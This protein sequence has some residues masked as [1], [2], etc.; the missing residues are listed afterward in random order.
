MVVCEPYLYAHTYACMHKWKNKKDLETFLTIIPL[1]VQRQDK[2]K[3]Y[4]SKILSWNT[5]TLKEF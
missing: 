4:K 5:G 3:S 2:S 1:G